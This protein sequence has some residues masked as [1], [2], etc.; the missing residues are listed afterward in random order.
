[1][2]FFYNFFIHSYYL[3][4][5]IASAFNK[6]AALWIS[7]RKNIFNKLR[8]II[9]T[10]DKIVWFHAASLGEFEQGRPVLEAFKKKFPE[11]KILLTFFSPSGYEIRKNYKEA[12]YVFYL[13]IDTY[14]NARKFIEIVK[15]S[16]V[17]FIKY[18]FW[19]NY[20]KALRKAEI[21]VYFISSV[22]REKQHFFKWYGA[23]F[24]K[25][26]ESITYF[27]VQNEKS[28]DLL[29]TIGLTNVIVSGDTR[30]D[31]VQDL[32]KKSKEFPLIE[33]FKNGKSLFIAGSTWQPDEEIIFDFINKKNKNL[34]FII[35]PHET[36]NDRINSICKIKEDK[37]I[38]FS[39]LTSG[40]FK[41][42][43]ILNAEILVIDSVGILKHLYKYATATYIGGG[44]G[45]DIHNIQEPVTFGKPVIFGP[46][47]HKFEEAVE[48]VKLR[49][50]FSITNQEELI[51]ATEKLLNDKSYYTKCSNICKKYI[52][53]KTGATERILE[54]INKTCFFVLG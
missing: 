28:K 14:A 1:M 30:F 20:L 48:L 5:L 13:P 38:K 40:K 26:L 44:F 53:S 12:D 46:K 9:S 16:K 21:P 49:G 47:Y 34:K 15:P 32:S 35:A 41:E 27:F 23:W 4:I 22:F 11:Y 8:S 6:K 52:T 2:S 25:Q 10:D 24:R 39:E 29:N 50:A 42:S 45:V 3:A 7:G 36:N 18:E 17:F 33:K 37:T 31:R 19:F 43:E 51:G 54:I